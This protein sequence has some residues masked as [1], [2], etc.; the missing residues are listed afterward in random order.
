MQQQQQLLPTPPPFA[1]SF[2]HVNDKRDLG[3]WHNAA[4]QRLVRSLLRGALVHFAYVFRFRS[5][6]FSWGDDEWGGEGC[7]F[8]LAPRNPPFNAVTSSRYL[9][10]AAAAA[11]RIT[12]SCVRC[13]SFFWGSW[14]GFFVCS[15]VFI[16]SFFF[17]ASRSAT[18]PCWLLW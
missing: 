5:K 14:E 6:T 2:A 18:Y 8:S 17:G 12:A 1:S 4:E 13:R 11:A 3:R 16:T 10:F 9:Q 7:S 15:E